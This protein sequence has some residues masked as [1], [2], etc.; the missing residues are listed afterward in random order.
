MPAYDAE[1][2]ALWDAWSD[3]HQAMWNVDTEDG[4]LPP[5]YSPSRTRSR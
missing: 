3:D 1:N 5:V 4:G 2:Q